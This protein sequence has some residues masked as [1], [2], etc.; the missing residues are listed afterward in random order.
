MDK[1]ILNN[2]EINR[3]PSNESVFIVFSDTRAAEGQ[4]LRNGQNDT[5]LSMYSAEA[6]PNPADTRSP[7]NPETP[8]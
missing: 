2:V 4:T 1:L 6:E 8:I 5:Q 7:T 3:L